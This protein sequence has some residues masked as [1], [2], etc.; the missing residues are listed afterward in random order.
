MVAFLQSLPSDYIQNQKAV[1]ESI[2]KSIDADVKGYLSTRFSLKAS[3]RPH[4]LKF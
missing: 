4:L 1:D 2:L 3:D